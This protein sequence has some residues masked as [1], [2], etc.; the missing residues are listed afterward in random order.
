MRTVLRVAELFVQHFHD[1]EVD[2]VADEVGQGERAHRVVGAQHHA[3]VDVLSAGDAV[4]EDADSLVDHRDE[5]AVDDEA[6]GFLHL[7]GLFADGRGQFNDALGDL[8]A[9]ELSLDD[10]NKGHTVGGVKEVHADELGGTG[11][12]GGDFGNR[13]RGRVGGE[14]GLGLADLVKFHE[15]I[16]LQLHLFDGG[17]DD[18][19]GV[20]KGGVVGGGGDVL[21]KGVNGL[22][23]HLAFFHQFAITFGDGSHSLIKAGLGAALHDDGH[24]GGESL[25]DSLG[26]GSGSDNTDFHDLIVYLLI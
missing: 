9:G 21:Q 15:H 20:S 23:G 17:F 3:L 8:V 14:D 18:E 2:I 19:V 16:F 22:L 10:F 1:G 7:H 13:Q 24:L 5:D 26:H 6:G 4:G 11:R 25:H 12:A